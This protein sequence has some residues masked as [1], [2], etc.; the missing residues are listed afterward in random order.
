MQF[1]LSQNID[2]I[3]SAAI[4][5]SPL[6]RYELNV[7]SREPIRLQNS[8]YPAVGYIITRIIRTS[9]NVIR[10]NF[11]STGNIDLPLKNS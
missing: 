9:V 11:A 2:I 6:D 8:S 4:L 5:F 1:L 10:L 7:S 3:F